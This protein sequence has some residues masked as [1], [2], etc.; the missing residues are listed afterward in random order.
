MALLEALTKR[1]S[2]NSIFIFAHYL[3]DC[4]LNLFVSGPIPPDHINIQAETNSLRLSWDIPKL[5]GAPNI[6]Y[7]VTYQSEGG[8]PKEIITMENSAEL[9]DLSSGT[10]YDITLVTIGP[11]NLTSE[12][13]NRSAAT[14][15]F[16]PGTLGAKWFEN[17]FI[18]LLTCPAQRF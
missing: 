16:H 5:H 6:S 7:N 17:C 10:L 9:I 8:Q 1:V 12:S 18:L 13:I 3:K 2:A 4:C 11:Q 15:E 14:C